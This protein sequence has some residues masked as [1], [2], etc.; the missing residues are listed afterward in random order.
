MFF[1][2]SLDEFIDS[3]DTPLLP[4]EERD[5]KIKK[6]STFRGVPKKE[7]K[8]FLALIL[9]P[10]FAKKLKWISKDISRKIL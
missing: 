8:A 4:D 7:L 5:V 3:F 6:T 9:Y 10:N 2:K 1:E